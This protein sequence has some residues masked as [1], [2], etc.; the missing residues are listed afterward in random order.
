MWGANVARIGETNYTSFEN[1]LSA[2]TAGQ[3]IVLLANIGTKSS[4]AVTIS[5]NITIDG[6]GQYS[7]SRYFTVNASKSLTLKDITVCNNKK[8]SSAPRTVTLKNGSHLI[9]SNATIV[10]NQSHIAVG[11]AASASAYIDLVEETNNT[12]R[13]YTGNTTMYLSSTSSSYALYIQGNGTLNVEHV[14][15][16]GFALGCVQATSSAK[17]VVTAPNFNVT[18]EAA[19]RVFS[20]YLTTS[21]LT[22]GIY[23][24]KPAADLVNDQSLIF[25]MT[26][27]NAGKYEVI[28][29]INAGTYGVKASIDKLAYTSLAAAIDAA[30]VGDEIKLWADA[31][32]IEVTKSIYI[33]P[34]GRDGSAITAGSGYARASRTE[35]FYPY[36]DYYFFGAVNSTI[37]GGKTIYLPTNSSELAFAASVAA[38]GE[39]IRV[40]ADITLNEKIEFVGDITFDLNGKTITCSGNNYLGV[41]DEVVTFVDGSAGQTGTVTTSDYICLGISKQEAT[42]KAIINGGK[43]ISTK[44]TDSKPNIENA[45]II[46]DAGAELEINGGRIQSNNNAIYAK[47][48]TGKKYKEYLGWVADNTVVWPAYVT[49]NNGEVVSSGEEAICMAGNSAQGGNPY[50]SKLTMTAGTITGTKHGVV[51][52][53]NGATFDMQ[54]G[55]INV[56]NGFGIAGNGKVGNGDENT[57]NNP[58][59]WVDYGGTSITISGGSVSSTNAAGIYQPQAGD[60][61]IEGG[62]VTGQTGIAI[63]SGTLEVTGGTI[64]ATGEKVVYEKGYNGGALQTGAAISIESNSVYAGNMSISVGGTAVLESAEGYA[65]YE[66]VDSPSN[67]THVDD[68][69][70]TGGTFEGGVSVSQDL[71]A[72]GGF[73]SGGTW[74]EDVIAHVADGKTTNAGAG[75]TYTIGTTTAATNFDGVNANS[76]VEISAD[77]NIT[78]AKEV[79]KLTVDAGVVTVK[80]DAVLKVGKGAVLLKGTGKLIV[81]AGGTLLVDG[82]IYGAG[83]TNL[84]IWT[85]ED[86][87]ATVLFSPETGFIKEDHPTATYK[88]H[89]KARKYEGEYVWQR[90][91]IPTFD[92]QTTMSWEEDEQTALY[93]FDYEKN[94]WGSPFRIGKGPFE[95]T[96]KPFQCYDMTTTSTTELDYTFTGSLMG[97]T[98]ASLDFVK[99]WNYFANCYTA[100]IDLKAFIGALMEKYGVDARIAA[101]IYLYNRDAMVESWL[102]VTWGQLRRK[103]YSGP[104]QIMPM[105][106]FIMQ[107]RTGSSANENINYGTSVYTPIASKLP[108]SAPA[109]NEEEE[110]NAVDIVVSDGAKKAFMTLFE[111]PTC[112]E[113][114]N[115]GYDAE[116]Y[117]NNG[118]FSLYRELDGKKWQEYGTN[119]MSDK[120][121]TFETTVAGEYTVT[122]EN[123][124]GDVM[125]FYDKVTEQLTPMKD[126]ATYTFTIGAGK[127]ADRFVINPKDVPLPTA[128][129]VTDAAAVEVGKFVGED[130]QL[131]IRRADKVYTV[132]GQ[133]VK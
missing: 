82:L 109:R 58:G 56:T 26:G 24:D 13:N 112:S 132:Q 31:E 75:D 19:G 91:G 68:I 110:M 102:P 64:T 129:G 120:F 69:A 8:A 36:E 74:T 130:R 116:M 61:T 103:S 51:L 90:F 98:N 78:A 4:E 62:A 39:G 67:P 47:A 122:F 92:G 97:N 125:Y 21:N 25:P 1:A 9:L 118:V 126:D 30:E 43:F 37:E 89:S 80:K 65:I 44:A 17:F 20:S 53:G 63:K 95:I 94:S 34:N 66:Y 108:A 77:Q 32:A 59:A 22:C 14:G 73:I 15:T 2:A 7:I 35:E 85:N 114:Y 84:E 6:Q 123:R 96:G 33:Y 27:E 127:H 55:T 81:E 12:I 38:D 52:M 23:S 128:I 121:L 106:A 54:G 104:K 107:L 40:A 41:Q 11:V 10:P 3:T 111:E 28:G 72:E 45:T 57:V 79:K 71:A 70:V 99:D 87:P 16:G 100:P 113:A 124:E 131:Y 115:N 5:K 18:S 60:V 119:D 86:N 117:D 83:T 29:T 76:I 50:L 101:T 48:S 133:E 105:Q 42:S 88:F 46:L 93:E 49:I